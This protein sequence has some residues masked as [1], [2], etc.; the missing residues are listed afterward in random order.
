M[1]MAIGEETSMKML[2]GIG[3][4]HSFGGLRAVDNADIQVEQGEIVGLIGPNGAGKT[5]LFNIVSGAIKPTE[6]R[7]MFKGEDITGMKPHLICH[8][9]M[10]RT[11]QTTKLFTNMSAFDNV[12]L[13][14]LFGNPERKIGRKEAE[15]EINQL[16]A[17]MGMLS[18]RNKPVKDMS[19]AMQKRLEIVRALATNPQM[20]L[21]DEVMSGL[22]QK[23]L[24]QSMQL[25]KQLRER[26]IT[27]FMIEHVMHAIMGV[28]D[29]IIVFHYGSKIA[30]GTPAEV[31]KDPTV[32]AVYLGK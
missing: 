15:K 4:S 10:A 8:R 18:D 1:A 12:K 29:R 27:I 13:A 25:V 5:T 16:F 31:V 2:E 32:N 11:F 7:V 26:G 3:I 19:L 21:L 20:L 23:E 24:I 14:L 6:G 9:G 22:T 30:E 28:C 17:V